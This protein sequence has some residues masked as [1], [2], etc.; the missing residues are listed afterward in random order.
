M[1]ETN[2]L[3]KSRSLAGVPSG[4]DSL[5]VRERYLRRRSQRRRLGDRGLAALWVTVGAV[6]SWIFVVGF[7]TLA[8]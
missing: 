6:V 4:I 8:R 7:T 5:R 2:T 3:R 1:P